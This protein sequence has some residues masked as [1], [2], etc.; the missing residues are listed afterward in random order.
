MGWGDILAMSCLR[1]NS[2]KRATN[3]KGVWGSLFSSATQK[4]PEPATSPKW[5]AL[6]EQAQGI[7]FAVKT[8]FVGLLHNMQKYGAVPGPLVRWWRT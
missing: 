4:T 3:T 2:N 6:D 1:S 7:P 8:M 5:I